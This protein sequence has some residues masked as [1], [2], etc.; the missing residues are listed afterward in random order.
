[1]LLNIKRLKVS[2]NT[3]SQLVYI[4]KLMM[5]IT[6]VNNA[7]TAITVSLSMNDSP[8][9]KVY[10]LRGLT[11]RLFIYIF[12]VNVDPRNNL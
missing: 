11:H 10:V 2:A 4:T 9:R 5:E 6:T 1:M 7:Q 3:L 8:P 12:I